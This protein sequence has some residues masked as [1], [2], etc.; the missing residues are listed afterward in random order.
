MIDILIV[1][2]CMQILRRVTTTNMAKNQTR[3]QSNPVG[4]PLF[5]LFS[6]SDLLICFIIYLNINY[7][8]KGSIG[9]RS[10]IKFYGG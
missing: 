7:W 8:F 9:L 3:L 6:T 10:Y 1:F 2:S 5:T 4:T